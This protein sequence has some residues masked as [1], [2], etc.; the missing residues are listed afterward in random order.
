MNLFYRWIEAFPWSKATVSVGKK[1]VGLE[2]IILS[3]CIPAELYS[4]HGTHFTRQV[5]FVKFDL[6]CNSFTVFISVPWI[7]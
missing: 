1:K 4:D 7:I 5:F 6:L 2:R 3:W